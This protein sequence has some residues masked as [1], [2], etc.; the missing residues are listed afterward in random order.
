MQAL[1]N[2]N[3]LHIILT[4]I[5]LIGSNANLSDLGPSALIS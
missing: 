4:I 2:A 5:V 3:K 1:E